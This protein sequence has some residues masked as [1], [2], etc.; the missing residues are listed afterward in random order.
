MSQ[1]WTEELGEPLST[2]LEVPVEVERVELIPGGASKDTCVVDAV[3]PEREL[4]LL[5]RRAAGGTIYSDTLSLEQECKVLQAA[6]KAGIK[7]PKPYGYLED[8]AGREAFVMERLEG[9]SVGRRIVQKPE[10]ETTREVLPKQLAEELSKIH[11]ISLEQLPSLPGGRIGPAADYVLSTLERELDALE[12]PHPVIELGLSWL[13][14][15]V[16]VSHGTVL[17]HGDF[18]VGNF[19]VD[20]EGLVGI[21]DWEFA[22]LGD[23]VE[24]LAWPLVRAWRFGKDH[25]RLGGIGE[26][27]PYLEHYNTLAGRQVTLEELFYWEVAGNVRWAIGSL[28][29]AKRHL[30]GQERNVELAVIGRLASEVEYEILS[31]LERG[32]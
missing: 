19:L 21:L 16:P 7:T 20:E 22:H 8:L 3:T 28:N 32:S 17:N 4:E 11:A 15:H 5:V 6:Y 18:R 23:P 10:F 14:E 25:L 29:Q 27:E 26:A 13:R 2:F 9:E 12:E 30:S 24:D 1:N 31:L